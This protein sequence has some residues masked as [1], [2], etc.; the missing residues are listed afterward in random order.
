MPLEEFGAVMDQVFGPGVGAAA[1]A[2]Y[3]FQADNAHLLPMTADMG[4][5]LAMLPVQMT[6]LAEWAAAHQAAF[7]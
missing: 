7:S 5:V 2:G 1:A 4:P 3:K 6:T